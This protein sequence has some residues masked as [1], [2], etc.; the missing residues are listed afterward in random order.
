MRDLVVWVHLVLGYLKHEGSCYLGPYSAALKSWKLPF[1][2]GPKE[3]STRR[4]CCDKPKGGAANCL[5]TKTG[6]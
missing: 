2:I 6:H 5:D 3:R 4:T 1:E